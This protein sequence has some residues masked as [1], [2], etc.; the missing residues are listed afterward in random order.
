MHD[1]NGRAQGYRQ[2]APLD[3]RSRVLA[4]TAENDL[5][6]LIA[7]PFNDYGN[8]QRFIAMY[9]D[10]AR[11]CHA[12]NTWLINDGA[13]WAIDRMDAGHTLAQETMLE[14]TRQALATQNEAASKFASGCLNSQRITAA[15]REAQPHLAISPERLDVDPI[16]LNFLNGTVDLRTGTLQDHCSEDFI[17]KVL[18]YPYRPDVGCPVFLAFL[19]RILNG[20][21]DY[22]QKAVGYSLTGL[23]LKRRSSSVMV[24]A[25]TGRQPCFPHYGGYCKTMA[26]CSRSIP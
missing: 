12:F 8:A 17:T 26:R 20:L 11:Y 24:A 22:L 23:T 14:F 5:P 19:H 10:L 2:S 18:P 21:K 3:S 16:L 1:F 9:G 13:Y 7:Q 15:L 4:P 6:H 25:T